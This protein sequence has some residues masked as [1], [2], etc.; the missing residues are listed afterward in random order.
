MSKGEL[1]NKVKVDVVPHY[2]DLSSYSAK[3]TWTEPFKTKQEH[4]LN[5]KITVGECSSNQWFSL[6]QVS[7][8]S[9]S[10]PIWSKLREPKVKC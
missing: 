1:K 6:F 8:Q 5:L 7:P 2:P 10:H 3:V 9:D 4:Q